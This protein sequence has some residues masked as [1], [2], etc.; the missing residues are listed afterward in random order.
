MDHELPSYTGGTHLI[1][2]PI[3]SLS[4]QCDG[5]SGM[6]SV[7]LVI[8]SPYRFDLLYIKYF[9]IFGKQT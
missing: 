6:L 1:L 9:F 5:G 3:A 2:N 8:A 7:G 4:K